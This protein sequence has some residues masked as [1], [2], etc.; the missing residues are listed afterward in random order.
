MLQDNSFGSS[1][2]SPPNFP[3]T[4]K[5][6]DSNT[7]RSTY[8]PQ[9]H[10]IPRLSERQLSDRSLD[11]HPPSLIASNSDPSAFMA[12]PRSTSTILIRK[13][14]RNF[15]ITEVNALL[16]F[17]EDLI[18]TEIVQSPRAEDNGYT[19]AVARFKSAAGAYQAQAMVQGKKMSQRDALIVVEIQTPISVDR[20]ATVDGIIPR[21]QTGSTSSTSSHGGP[22][23]PGRSRF[24]STFQSSDKISPPL[25]MPESAGNG[26]GNGHIQNLFS[27]ASP[28]TN[29]FNDRNRISGKS[30]INNDDDLDD[31][32][33]GELL[34]DPLGFAKSGQQLRRSSQAQVPVLSQFSRL[35]ISTGLNGSH[36]NFAPSPVTQGNARRGSQALQ[37]PHSPTNI[38]NMNPGSPYN[39]TMPRPQYPPINPADQNPPCNTLYV[40]NLPMDTSEDELKSIFMKARGYKRLCFRIK[41]NGPM[42]F[43]EFDDTTYATQALNELYG[44]PLHNSVKGGIRLSYSKNP[45]GVRSQANGIVQNGGYPHPL[46]LAA[47][48]YTNNSIDNHVNHVA[49]FQAVSGPPPG[50]ISPPGFN[51]GNSYSRPSHHESQSSASNNTMFRDPFS[52]DFMAQQYMEANFGTPAHHL[53]GGLP[54]N[55]SGRYGRDSRGSINSFQTMGR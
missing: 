26:N 47:A 32:E 42:C 38:T 52:T 27:P 39:M 23:P 54:P 31:D 41:S 1:T 19:T 51:S 21:Q 4:F 40:G 34:K 43:V 53:S 36:S 50:I 13:L 16:L 30:V 33:T 11:S 24:G 9:P 3:Y 7:S 10:T 17:S 55:M 2:T 15:G 25:P 44:A 49:N 6:A 5:Y 28:M 22:P 29:G 20:R 37:P 18:G 45:L 48:G 14:P 12:D 46:S 8:A 35:S